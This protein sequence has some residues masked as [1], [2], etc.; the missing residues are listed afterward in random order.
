MLIAAFILVISVAALM[1]FAMFAWRASL[2]RTVSEQYVNEADASLQPYPN[3]LSSTSFAEVK[4]VYRDLCPE[5][6]KGS[7]P[8][9]RAVSAYYAVMSFLGR[10]GRSILPAEGLNWTQR[11]MALC[12]QYATVRLSQRLERNISIVNQARSF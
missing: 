9:L 8:N 4:A 3:L 1:Q 10:V 7:T 12:T 11:E 2:L 6:E 5:L